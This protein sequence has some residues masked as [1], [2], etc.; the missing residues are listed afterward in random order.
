MFVSKRVG[1]VLSGGGVLGAAHIGVLEVL[2]E[3]AIRPFCVTG[4]SAGSAVGVVYCAGL[5]LERIKELALAMRWP[6]VG[7]VVL[8]R[9]GLLDGSRLEDYVV[10][11]IGDRTFDELRIPLAVAAADILT[12]ELVVLSE[13]RVAPAVR[14]SCAVPG[15]FTPVEYEGRLLVDGGIINNLP[16][17]A[18]RELGAEYVIAVDLYSPMAAARQAPSTLLGMWLLLLGILV[19]NT[20]REAAL[21]D[22]V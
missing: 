2:E 8:P 1:V 17:A 10:D 13:G 5:G 9:R 7:R 4:T 21:A 20:H 3:H 18:A 19:R 11:L 6:K 12:E 14:A 22:V 16:V 15:V